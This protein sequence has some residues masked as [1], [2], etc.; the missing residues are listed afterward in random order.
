MWRE[1]P[2]K[3]QAAED[4]AKAEREAERRAQREQQRALARQKVQLE[5]LEAQIHRFEGRMAELTAALERAGREQD[6]SRVSKLG[7]EYHQIESRLDHLLEEWAE[8]ADA[9]DAAAPGAQD[10]T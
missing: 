9:T 2:S 5:E 7:A 8:I 3:A 1:A 6:V 4:E 10:G